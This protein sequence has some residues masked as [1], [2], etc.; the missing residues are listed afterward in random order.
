MVN[1]ME[2]E[3]AYAKNLADEHWKFVSSI[4]ELMYKTA[5]EHGFKHGM[6]DDK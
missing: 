5:F 4:C 3:K 1:C 2:Y 6:E